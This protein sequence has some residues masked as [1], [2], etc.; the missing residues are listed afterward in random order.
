MEQCKCLESGIVILSS[1]KRLL[2]APLKLFV[3][4]TSS[5]D[6]VKEKLDLFR[7]GLQIKS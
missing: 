7:S 2:M 6:L 5:S 1:V 4:L 3:Y